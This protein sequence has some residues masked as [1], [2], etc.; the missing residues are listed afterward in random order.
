MTIIQMAMMETQGVVI[1]I[2]AFKLMQQIKA[3]NVIVNQ[4]MMM[5]MMTK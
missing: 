5:K 1:M 3:H 2:I 4:K